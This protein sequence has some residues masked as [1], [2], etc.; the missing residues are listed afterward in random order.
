MSRVLCSLKVFQAFSEQSPGPKLT[1]ACDSH[2]LRQISNGV[3]ED[4]GQS[5]ERKQIEWKIR[6][7][8]K[9]AVMQFP[10]LEPR[11]RSAR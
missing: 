11:D 3:I 6:Q 5:H 2:R 10:L 8:C 9:S 7:A 4:L 1:P